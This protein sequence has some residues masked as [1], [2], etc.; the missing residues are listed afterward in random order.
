[1]SRIV[2]AVAAGLLVSQVVASVLWW[3]GFY[4]FPP[5]PIYDMSPALAHAHPD[6]LPFA[7]MAFQALGQGLGVLLGGL[8]A[9]RIAGEGPR[10]AWA[11]GAISFAVAVIW[12]LFYPR[13]L[14]FPVFSALFVGG[15]AWFA[16]QVGQLAR[17]S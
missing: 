3:W 16:G 12:L 2:P 8:W 11:V 10:P 5:S 14:W 7:A 15:G 1:M 9:V 13:P 17:R 6:K 4:A